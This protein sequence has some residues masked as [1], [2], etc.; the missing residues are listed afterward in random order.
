MHIVRLFLGLASNINKCQ[1]VLLKLIGTEVKLRY[2]QHSFPSPL[3]STLSRSV[4]PQRHSPPAPSIA[5]GEIPHR[6]VAA[7]AA[8]HAGIV[9]YVYM[10]QSNGKLAA[11]AALDALVSRARADNAANKITGILVELNGTYLQ[12]LQGPTA[13]VSRLVANIEK[14]ERHTGF[15]ELISRPSRRLLQQAWGG[16]RVDRREDAGA[17]RERVATLPR[18]VNRDLPCAPEDFFRSLCWPGKPRLGAETAPPIRVVLFG[19]TLMW[20][21]AVVTAASVRQATHT[22]RTRFSDLA[23]DGRADTLVEYVDY[24]LTPEAPVRLMACEIS[25]LHN[26]LAVSIFCD[27]DVL[28]FMV[29]SLNSDHFCELIVNAAELCKQ[30]ITPPR[31]VFLLAKRVA[32]AEA[33]LCALASASGFEAEAILVATLADSRE[34][35]AAIETS[36]QVEAR[37]RR[38]PVKLQPTRATETANPSKGNAASIR[39]VAGK[40]TNLNAVPTLMSPASMM[41]SVATATPVA[42]AT[43]IAIPAESNV[44]TVATITP[45]HSA[46][47]TVVAEISQTALVPNKKN[48]SSFKP[49]IPSS[50]STPL[51]TSSESKTMANVT[52]T[53]NQILTIDGAMGCAL[54]DYTS[55]MTLGT[56]GGGIN[57]D[58]AAAGNTEVLRAKMKVANSLGLTGG[59]EDILVTLATQY[60]ILRP[61]VTQPGL[62]LYVVIDRTKGNLAMARFKISEVEKALKV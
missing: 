62:F 50:S 30:R 61:L 21:S 28:I 54:V 52:D 51:P 57:L 8:M 4:M 6:S 47:L 37:S 24:S 32:E 48:T 9:D 17:L 19:A 2:S 12:W 23:S 27:A 34:A 13:A 7:S 45:T 44:T 3:K 40:V 22:G 43:R 26:N 53:L 14:D 35:L 5:I 59:I 56:A 31:I 38:V 18:L 33:E 29:G 36:L 20:T 42:E 60:H 46:R 55:G 58:V 1:L 39:V 15:T 10:S 16:Y 25:S 49:I 11:S 41:T